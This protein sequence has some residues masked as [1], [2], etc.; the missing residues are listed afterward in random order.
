MIHPVR[1]GMRIMADHRVHERAFSLL[2][3][4][5]KSFKDSSLL[6]DI[7]LNQKQRK[8]IIIMCALPYI[9]TCICACVAGLLASFVFTLHANPV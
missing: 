1:V 2:F 9:R 6:Q 8:T 7:V 3:Q 4:S 5:A